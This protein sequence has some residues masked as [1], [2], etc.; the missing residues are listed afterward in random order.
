MKI[1]LSLLTIPLLSLIAC[2]SSQ[3]EPKSVKTY[4]IATRQLPPEPAFVSTRWVRPPQVYP[5]KTT[6]SKS[7]TPKVYPVMHLKLN[8]STYK[9]AA[10]VLAAPLNYRSYCS[11]SLAKRRITIDSLGTVDEL[12]SKIE[13]LSGMKVIVDHNEREVRI[14]GNSDG[15]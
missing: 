3:V 7:A 4:S 6:Q 13:A 11:E 5:S 10:M 2:S 9:N 14:Y 15:V 12:A 8:N 1:L